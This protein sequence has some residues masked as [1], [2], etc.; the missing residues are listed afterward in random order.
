RDRP[1]S[2]A[3]SREDQRLY[4][5]AVLRANERFG[6]RGAGA[7]VA[8]PLPGVASPLDRPRRPVTRA[9]AP[10][11]PAHP[12]APRIRPRPPAGRHDPRL[13]RRPR[14]PDP[15]GAVRSDLHE[16]RAARETR[17]LARSN[18]SPRKVSHAHTQN[19]E[20]HSNALHA[21]PASLAD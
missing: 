6:K 17:G 21:R 4:P 16:R 18:A 1:P 14:R 12:P 10:T 7:A 2:R 19:N 3:P 20:H 5:S 15:P 8:K 11:H 13:V 9:D